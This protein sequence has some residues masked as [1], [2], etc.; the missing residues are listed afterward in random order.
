MDVSCP[1]CGEKI[2]GSRQLIDSCPSCMKPW[3]QAL[4]ASNVKN[5]NSDPIEDIKEFVVNAFH[6]A[7]RDALWNKT[8]T[9]IEKSHVYDI[10]STI[11]TN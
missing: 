8:G 7:Q 9:R 10:V 5:G 4:F 1:H 11:L 6:K 2:E 3:R